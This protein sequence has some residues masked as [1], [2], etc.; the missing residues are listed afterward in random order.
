MKKL[1]NQKG[2]TLIE[3]VV[4]IVIL[5]ILAATAAP[6]FI[7]LTSD[8]RISVMEG[9]VGSMN[10]AV[11]LAQSKALIEGET[12]ATGAIEVNNTFYALEFGYPVAVPLGDG[13]TDATG[14]SIIS[15]VDLDDLTI[16]SG[17]GAPTAGL[18]YDS[19]TGVL[20]NY[21]ANTPAD[22][23]ITYTDSTGVEVRPGIAFVDTGC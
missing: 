23:T 8:A 5:G 2:F 14:L 20:T 9:I 22:C 13:G 10:G 6:R 11:N 15:L 19:S 16:H 4:V 18:G 12:A 1:S 3:L 21:D 17:S 7:D